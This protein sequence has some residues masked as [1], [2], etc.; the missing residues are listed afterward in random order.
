[1]PEWKPEILR[2]LG[3]L[4]LAP[5][6]EAEIAEEVAQHLEERYRE[7]VAT[8]QS[9]D[10]AFRAAI[11]ELRGGDFLA[12]SLRRAEKNFYREPI[13]PGKEVT[14]FFSAIF[15]DM[16]YAIRTCAKRRSSRA[17]R[18]FLLRWELARTQQSS[19]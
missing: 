18:L 19:A 2:R 3:P 16:R 10:T 7:L 5:T 4:K 15:Q 12:R 11:D 1:M 14:N 13:V 6:R 8:G 17:S 9:E